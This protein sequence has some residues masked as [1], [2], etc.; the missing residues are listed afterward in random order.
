MPS[1]FQTLL[2]IF[3]FFIGSLF[4]RCFSSAL[5]TCIFLC[6][7]LIL[8]AFI[9]ST[10]TGNYSQLDELWSLAPLFYSFHLIHWTPRGI[11]M[12]LLVTIWGIRLSYN[13]WRKGGYRGGE[14]YRWGILREII[15][16]P[17]L[18][19]MFS[20]AFI[21]F[22][23]NA[24]LL[25]IC[26]PCYFDQG[27]KIGLVDLGLGL[28]VIGLILVE[29]IADN[30]QWQFQC[31]KK[32]NREI[33]RENQSEFV[34]TGMFYYSRHPNYFAEIGIWWGIYA[35]TMSVNWSGIGALL[36]TL[37]FQGTVAFT[38]GISAKKYHNY[39]EYQR[40]TSRLVPWFKYLEYKN[41]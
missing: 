4:F 41:Q 37:L 27:D 25:L 21:S 20:F 22:Y 1:A 30:Q 32:R 23:Q 6:A 38:E 17:I 2:Q 39:G 31:E 13:F 8:Y 24:L 3:S 26:L 12:L 5:E 29:T 14:D 19:T 7:S 18:W 40:S 34:N 33:G 9:K 11:L 10:V 36:L 28:G 16:N 15:P 35:F